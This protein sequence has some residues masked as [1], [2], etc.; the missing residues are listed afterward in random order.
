MLE[1]VEQSGLWDLLELKLPS[2]PVFTLKK[3]RMKYSSVV[4]EACAQ[5]REYSNFFDSKSNQDKIYQKYGLR[6][7]RP[8]MFVIIG[9]K[10]SISPV[11]RR[12]IRK[13]Y[14]SPERKYI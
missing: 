8:K 6:S 11:N 4:M 9:R 10:G 7:F 3:R 13:R 14:S 2:T 12:K 5:L 1:P